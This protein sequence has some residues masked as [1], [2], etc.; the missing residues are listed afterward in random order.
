MPIY[1]D[2]KLRTFYN[3]MQSIA[4]ANIAQPSTNYASASPS[5]GLYYRH[6]ND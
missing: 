5:N 6:H 1:W 2:N 4:D 3:T